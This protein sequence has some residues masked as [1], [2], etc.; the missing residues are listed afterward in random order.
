MFVTLVIMSVISCTQ[1]V[2]DNF[3]QEEP[4]YDLSQV[5]V[6]SEGRINAREYIESQLTRDEVVPVCNLEALDDAWWYGGHRDGYL[7]Y[8]YETST[9]LHVGTGKAFYNDYVK[10]IFKDEWKSGR[11]SIKGGLFQPVG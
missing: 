9:Y 4:L 5:R 8:W 7:A 3:T 1:K 11:Y 6:V 2:D 10:K